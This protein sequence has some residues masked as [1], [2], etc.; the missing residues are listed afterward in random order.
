MQTFGS[1]PSVVTWTVQ[2]LQPQPLVEPYYNS[3]NFMM[4]QCP[5]CDPTKSDHKGNGM[6]WRKFTKEHLEGLEPIW[7]RCFWCKEGRLYQI[8]LTPDLY[9]EIKDEL[10][11]RQ[12]P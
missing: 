2:A 12:L 11:L 5:F 4:W 6:R 9:R 8:K 7:R 1:S 3:A 10:S